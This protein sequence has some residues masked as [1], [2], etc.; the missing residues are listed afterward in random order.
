MIVYLVTADHEYTIR[1]Y[2][3]KWL[4]GSNLHIQVIHYEHQPWRWLQGAA[5]YIFSD[6]ERLTP[7]ERAAATAYADTLQARGYPVLNHPRQVLTRMPL[8]AKLHE[9]GINPFRA[10][11]VD[12]LAQ[13]AFPMFL[14]RAN[15]HLGSMGELIPDA[16]QLAARL[17]ALHA[18]GPLPPDL[19]GVEFCDTSDETGR[20]VKYSAECIGGQL[21]PHHCLTSQA[22]LIK[23]PDIL[24]ESAVQL[25]LQFLAEFP[26]R[27]AVQRV[28]DLAHITFGRIDYSVQAGEIRVWEINTN[29]TIMPDPDKLAPVRRASTLRCGEAVADAFDVLNVGASA[30]SLYWRYI[31]V[32]HRLQRKIAK[33]RRPKHAIPRL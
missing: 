19:I 14:R 2:Q 33:L 30:R 5:T 4:A 17:A 21:L 10:F 8:L 27:E 3:R 11:P 23:Y 16:T 1:R 31:A 20:F 29:P 26:H 6:I 18:E 25:E 13:C 15:T 28:F 32:R 22:W 9:V 12:Q 24:D 7:D